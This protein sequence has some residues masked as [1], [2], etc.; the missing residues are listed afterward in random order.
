MLRV[1]VIGGK[2]QGLEVSYLAKAAG[3]YVIVAD[4]SEEITCNKVADEHIQI[5]ALNKEAMLKLVSSVDVIIPAIEGKKEIKITYIQPKIFYIS[6]LISI[7]SSILF[8]VFMKRDLS[9]TADENVSNHR[10]K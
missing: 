8:Y 9:K 5:D 4:K 7:L 6:Y 3:Y 2:L 1:L 10:I